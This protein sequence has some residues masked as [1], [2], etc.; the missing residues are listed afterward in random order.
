MDHNISPNALLAPPECQVGSDYELPGSAVA[1]KRVKHTCAALHLSCTSRAAFKKE[2]KESE[3]LFLV[4]S[5]VWL[6]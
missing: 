3:E 6:M 2:I 4:A 1:E 5:L